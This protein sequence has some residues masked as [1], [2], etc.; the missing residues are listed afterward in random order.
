MKQ[1]QLQ[2]KE[3]ATD[4]KNTKR[5]YVGPVATEFVATKTGI[6]R[7][8]RPD[9]AIENCS[10]CG[11]CRKHCPTDVIIVEK[12]GDN[13]GVHFDWD[14]CK[15]CGICANVCPKKCIAMIPEAGACDL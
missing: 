7:T 4:C 3:P 11:T 12:D 2:H 14:Y 10:F 6:W 15:G 8:E 13:R 1:M 5:Y 9:V